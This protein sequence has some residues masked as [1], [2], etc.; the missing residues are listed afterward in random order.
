MACAWG[1]VIVT[2]TYS[3][4]PGTY[5][6]K[7][8]AVMSLSTDAVAIGKNVQLGLDQFIDGGQWPVDWSTYQ[9]PTLA[10]AGV[11]TWREWVNGR[12]KNL[13]QDKARKIIFRVQSERPHLKLSSGCN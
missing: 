7:F 13:R 3:P 12:L 4:G 8:P 5:V 11:T 2:S 6:D 10:V 1:Y 9:S